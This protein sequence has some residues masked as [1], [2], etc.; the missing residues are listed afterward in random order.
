[1]ITR[2]Y[3]L[4]QIHQLSQVLAA[5][6]FGKRA[7]Q[8]EEAQEALAHGLEDAL[9]LPLADLHQLG[10]DEVLALCEHAGAFSSEKALALADLLRED[11]S[12]AG[13]ERALWLYEAARDM[14]DL[15][16]LDLPERI[17]DLRDAL[18]RG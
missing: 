14:G 16:P 11:T 18:A 12:A 15:A 13:R 3:I 9:G 2:D 1:M 4:R 6:L 17:A 10:K 7:G 5:V 8:T